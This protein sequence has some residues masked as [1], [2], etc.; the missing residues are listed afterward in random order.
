ME[1]NYS[2]LEEIRQYLAGELPDKEAAA[3]EQKI[4][5]DEQYAFHYR[6]FRAA[7]RG[8]RQ[9]RISELETELA[10]EETEEGVDSEPVA[11]ILRIDRVRTRRRM[12]TALISAAAVIILLIIGW[13]QLQLGSSDS[14]R[15]PAVVDVPGG[16]EEIIPGASGARSIAIPIRSFSTT[17][18]VIESPEETGEMR[19][20]ESP[21][22]ELNYLLNGLSLIVFT[23][24]PASLNTA[25]I[26]WLKVE[27]DGAWSYFLKIGEDVYS[28]KPSKE[29]T[30]L[31]KAP[32][33]SLP[34]YLK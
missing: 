23:D 12:T 22:A 32:P 5:S 27:R 28:L 16:E 24:D 10:A 6:S 21:S 1:I 33:E 8:I 20:I 2:I 9:K 30:P 3:L 19:I 31:P 7:E 29:K 26:Q 4:R 18:D 11:R 14:P 25:D 34:K 13:N 17:G 15:G